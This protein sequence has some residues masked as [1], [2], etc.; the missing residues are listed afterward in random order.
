MVLDGFVIGL[1]SG[2]LTKKPF[3]IIPRLG[4]HADRQISVWMVVRLVDL[5]RRMPIWLNSWT[6]RVAVFRLQP[7]NRARSTLEA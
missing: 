3:F 7:H 6:M 4:N 2:L 5:D 1:T